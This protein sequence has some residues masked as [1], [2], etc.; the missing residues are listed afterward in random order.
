MEKVIPFGTNKV[1]GRVS[2]GGSNAGSTANGAA[3]ADA[4]N[5]LDY[6]EQ[7]LLLLQRLIGCTCHNELL[8]RYFRWTSELGLADGITFESPLGHEPKTLGARRHHSA[9]YDLTLEQSYLGS[10]TLCRRE[11]FSEKVLML[12]EQSLGSLARCLKAAFEMISLKSS[13]TVDP[14]TGV[15]NR[16][17]LDDWL[18]TE[19]SRTRRHD[20]PLA[21]MMIDVDHFKTLNDRL[22]HLGGDRILK[23]IANVLK[24]GTRGSDLIFRFGGDEFTIL[25]PHTDAEGAAQAA[26][27]IR[28]NLQRLTDEE[29][30]LTDEAEGI[31]PDISVGVAAYI[32]GDDA[33]ALMRRADT[34]LYHAKASG[35]GCVCSAL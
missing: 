1:E 31:R 23:A 12:I 27:Q 30:G 32:A 4:A 3:V 7:H 10:I 21:V 19:I 11:R 34:H 9:N 20:T 22:G 2:K 16:S 33:D 18:Q 28:S 5:W 17:P 35:R 25:L 15:L 14:L 29:L 8:Q 13:A 24:K 6:T 26:R